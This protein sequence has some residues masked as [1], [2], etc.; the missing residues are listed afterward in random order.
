M[1]ID[2]TTMF[3]V[4][5]NATPVSTMRDVLSYTNLSGLL[6]Q[7]R[8]GLDL[9]KHDPTIFVDREEAMREASA[10]LEAAAE[11]GD[12]H[13]EWLAYNDALREGRHADAAH[14]RAAWI[15]AGKR[16][17]EAK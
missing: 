17:L 11:G 6:L 3:Y 7:F 8:G 14:H 16:V 10:R 5:T 13:A 4:V 15:R 1:T 12:V 2:R 9:V